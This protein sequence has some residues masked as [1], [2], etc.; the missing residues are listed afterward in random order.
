MELAS[1]T[2]SKAVIP[3]AGLGTRLLSVTKE[4]PKEMLGVFALGRKKDVA[5]KPVVQLIYEQL[6][7]SGVRRF[8]FVVGRGKR[9]IEDHFTLDNEFVRMLEAKGRKAQ[10]SEL[11]SFYERV[12][13]SN[14]SW[15][16]QSEPRGFGDAVLCAE[17]ALG[18]GPFLVHAG[19]NH[20]ISR[21]NAHLARMLRDK[22]LGDVAATL[23]L[24]RVPDP[25]SYGTAEIESVRGETIVRRVEEKPKRPTSNLA[26]LPVYLFEPVILDALRATKKGINGEIQLTDAIQNLI[27]R[28]L[29]VNATTLRPGEFWLDVG[30]PET[31][32]NALEISHSNLTKKGKK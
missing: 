14:I 15:V 20:V 19:D 6:Y 31:Y 13:Q 5:M 8:I 32:W 2:I 28:G 12:R 10:A 3:A 24:R 26:L 1:P 25:R 30:T 23:L 27:D 17:P 4:Q 7:D 21:R 22:H 11:E 16:N 29:K 18:D 9:A